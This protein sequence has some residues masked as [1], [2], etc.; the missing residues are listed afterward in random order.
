MADNTCALDLGVVSTREKITQLNKYNNNF[1][2]N[3][4]TVINADL[5]PSVGTAMWIS[6]T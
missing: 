4:I 3:Y 6:G 1:P 5:W 2:Y